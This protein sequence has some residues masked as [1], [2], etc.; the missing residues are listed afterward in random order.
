MA[1]M[2]TQTSTF[3]VLIFIGRP[4]AGKSEIIDY[5]KKMPDGA[6]CAK[7]HI[8]PFV[9]IDDFVWVW[10]IFEDD[11]VWERL[12]R[13]RLLTDKNL[14]GGQ[15]TS[16]GLSTSVINDATTNHTS[17]SFDHYLNLS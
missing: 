17:L 4:A 13:E 7:L 10:Q 8:A 3:P 14:G 15:A 16:D 12:G 11:L 9:E 6:R 5:L 2:S 1:S